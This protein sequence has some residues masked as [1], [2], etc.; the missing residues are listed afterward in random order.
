MVKR[1]NKA[2]I[3]G[4][5]YHGYVGQNIMGSGSDIPWIGVI[6]TMG[7]SV[8]IPWVEGSKYYWW[9]FNIPW[10]GFWISCVG[11]SK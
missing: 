11:W 7:R 3:G 1:F 10:I 8:Q 9:G 2:W 4:S 6:Y 5:E